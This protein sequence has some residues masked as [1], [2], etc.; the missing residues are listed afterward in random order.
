MRDKTSILRGEHWYLISKE[1]LDS[2]RRF[3]LE[4]VNEI[5]GPIDNNILLL[6]AGMPKLGLIKGQHY[7]GVTK[8]VWMYF[9]DI[10]G[11]GPAIIRKEIDIYSA[12]IK[13][14]KI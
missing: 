3:V 12:P 2:W 8:A 4:G 5:P 9:I 11:G 14:S 10:Y 1:W 6:Q 7:R 13:E